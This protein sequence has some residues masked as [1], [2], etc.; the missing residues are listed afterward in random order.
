[1]QLQRRPQIIVCTPG[2]LSDLVNSGLLSL[3]NISYVVLDEADRLL[4]MGFEPAIR[5]VLSQIRPD[6]QISLFTA[7]WPKEVRALASEFMGKSFYRLT[8]G[9]S[10][11]PAKSVSQHIEFCEEFE[12]AELLAGVLRLK[13]DEQKHFKALVFCNTKNSS[14]MLTNYLKKFNFNAECF[15]GDMTQGARTQAFNKFK[16][17]RLDVLIA[18]DA[19]ARGLDVKDISL[20]VNHDFPRDMETYIHRI[21]RTG[22][23][24][25]KGESISFVTQN[26]Q[27]QFSQIIKLLTL[28]NQPIPP[29]LLQSSFS[30]QS[31]HVSHSRGGYRNN[32]RSYR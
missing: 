11:S 25:A 1:M 17:G 26:E 5:A 15:H 4:D 12:K 24:G 3:Q 29:E 10:L 13:K 31:T 32:A 22:R 28:G 23:A 14:E 7:T 18:S 27:K 20:V 6:R 21:G 19:A 30:R 2:R 9:K 16:L 8:V